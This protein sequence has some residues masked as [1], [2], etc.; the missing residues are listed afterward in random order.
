MSEGVR[1]KE[2]FLRMPRLGYNRRDAALLGKNVAER[3][4]IFRE[5]IRK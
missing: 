4:T 3:K 2:L 1:R 5:G